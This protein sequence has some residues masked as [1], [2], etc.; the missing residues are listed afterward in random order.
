MRDQACFRRTGG[1]VRRKYN[2][3]WVSRNLVGVRRD[4]VWVR[5]DVK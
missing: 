4:L 3:G 5:T 2:F 1:W